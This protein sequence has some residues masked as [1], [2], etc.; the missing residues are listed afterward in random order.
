MKNLNQTETKKSSTGFLLLFAVITAGILI[1][2]IYSTGHTVTSP[3]VHQYLL[4]ECSGSTIYEVFRNT[5]MS[6]FLFTVTAFVMGLSAFGQP[7]GII[8]LIYRGFGIGT[9]VSSEY[10]S[11]GLHGIPTVLVLILPECI[12]VTVISVLAV[13]ELIR[14]S[15]SVSRFVV[16]DINHTDKSFKLYC[17]EFLVLIAVSLV[18]AVLATVLNYAFSGLR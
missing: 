8:M 1:G 13:R 16:S 7:A 10:L 6:L 2:A 14:M 3:W 5:F 9:A 15:R 17:L 18:I 12:A 4:P 11:K